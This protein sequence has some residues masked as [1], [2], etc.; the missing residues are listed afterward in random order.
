MGVV[1]FIFSVSLSP[2]QAEEGGSL[3]SNETPSDIELQARAKYWDSRGRADLADKERS[4]IRRVTFVSAQSV[5]AVKPASSVFVSLPPVTESKPL[6]VS[7]APL[8]QS[9]AQTKPDSVK[10]ADNAQY[11]ESR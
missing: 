4:R 10:S 9:Q 2:L 3:Q 11:W 7:V 8:S 5:A 6:V 1:L